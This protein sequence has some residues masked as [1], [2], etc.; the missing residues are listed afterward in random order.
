MVEQTED[1][2]AI[3]SKQKTTERIQGFTMV[4]VYFGTS[5]GTS[6]PKTGKERSKITGEF[7]E[8]PAKS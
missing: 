3:I 1:H 4:N 2:D 5:S 6:S 8:N 7:S